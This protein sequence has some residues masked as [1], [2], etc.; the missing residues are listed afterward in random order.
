[1]GRVDEAKAEFEKA[2]SLT[3]AVDSALVDKISGDHPTQKPAPQQ[4]AEPVNKP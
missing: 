3:K 2:S 4:A 1:M